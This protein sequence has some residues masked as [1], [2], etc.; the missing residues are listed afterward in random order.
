[1]YSQDQMDSFDRILRTVQSGSYSMAGIVNQL[2]NGLERASKEYNKYSR[3]IKNDLAVLHELSYISDPTPSKLIQLLSKGLLATQGNGFKST[4]SIEL[5]KNRSG[6]NESEKSILIDAAIKKLAISNG[7]LPELL[8][9]FQNFPPFNS[10]L[11]RKYRIIENELLRFGLAEKIGGGDNSTLN[12]Y[13]RLKITA[14]GQEFYLSQ[15][16]SLQLYNHSVQSIEIN[17]S[18]MLDIF[19]SHSSKD[20]EIASRLIRLLKSALN[21]SPEKIRCT[22]VPGYKL[23]GGTNTDEQLRLEVT[24]CKV[25][26][27]IVSESSLES[28][29]VLF[30]LGARWGQ[31]LP[32]KPIVFSSSHLSKVGGPL[33]NL[34]IIN[35]SNQSEIHQ[36][37]EEISRTLGKSLTST[38]AFIDDISHLLEHIKSIKINETSPSPEIIPQQNEKEYFSEEQKTILVEASQD[39]S[40]RI[41]IIRTQDGY[42]IQTNGKSFCN[43]YEGRIR[44]AWESAISSLEDEGLIESKNVGSTIYTITEKGYRVVDKLT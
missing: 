25:L 30:E 10:D 34:H 11:D 37:I 13:L 21:L 19:I 7:L 35:V 18:N 39:T 22:S 3:A 24:T 43:T 9:G 26:I 14:V 4:T 1:M 31:K 8:D 40:G 29:Y 44:A 23:E 16:S 12:G 28:M 20:I 32:F 41:S 38:A 36:L 27:G 33:H 17:S 6:F 5:T 2:T 42:K 15:K